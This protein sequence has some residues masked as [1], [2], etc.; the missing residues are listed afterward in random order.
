M[1]R[2]FRVAREC[3]YRKKLDE[4]IE[5]MRKQKDFINHFFKE[6]DI[7][8]AQYNLSGTGFI[9]CPFKEKDK[10]EIVLSI[11]PKKE[12]KE[13]FKDILCKPR[14]NELCQFRKNSE[15][16]KA[17]RNEAV[18]NEIPINVHEPSL[19]NYFQSIRYSAY[20]YERFFL[21]IYCYVMIDGDTLSEDETPDGF[22]EIKLSEYY[23]KLEEMRDAK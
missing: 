4:Y 8:A 3:E 10:K 6:H 13:K 9:N 15:I 12:D 18:K 11:V 16:G 17:V 20:R 2:T 22:E 5:N 23:L 7:K 14:K 19:R 21:D 1:Q